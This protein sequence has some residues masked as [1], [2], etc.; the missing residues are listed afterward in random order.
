M[1]VTMKTLIERLEGQNEITDLC[2]E[3]AQVIKTL[4]RQRDLFGESLFLIL[5]KLNVL[6]I[7]AEPNGPELLLAAQE[8]LSD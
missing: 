5:V 4:Q 2:T 1:H 7:H 8:Y 6:H 3:A